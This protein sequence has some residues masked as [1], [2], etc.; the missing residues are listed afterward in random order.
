MLPIV[1]SCHLC[2][3]G[4]VGPWLLQVQQY[5][6][7]CF[8]SGFRYMRFITCSA[9]WVDKRIQLGPGVTK[10]KTHLYCG[11]IRQWCI[12]CDGDRTTFWSQSLY[13]ARLADEQP[14]AVHSIWQVQ[15][16]SGVLCIQ[17]SLYSKVASPI[18][19]KSGVLSLQAKN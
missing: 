1:G 6:Q 11:L 4:C 7:Y 12:P 5:T 18:Y 2:T 9:C 14:L 15:N 19:L 10:C 8:V 17:G 3:L 13:S 16:H